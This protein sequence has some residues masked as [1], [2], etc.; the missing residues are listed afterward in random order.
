MAE[1]FSF[2]FY[3]FASLRL[4]PKGSSGELEGGHGSG[5]DVHV[6]LISKTAATQKKKLAKYNKPLQLEKKKERQVFFFFL[7][8]RVFVVCLIR[9]RP[10]LGAGRSAYVQDERSVEL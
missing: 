4:Q 5:R 10:V 2:V 7:R 1:G 9:F 3:F 6:N 8:Q